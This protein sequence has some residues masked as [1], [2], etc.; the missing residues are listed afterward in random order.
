MKDTAKGCMLLELMHSSSFAQWAL[1]FGIA[2]AEVIAR[3]SSKDGISLHCRGRHCKGACRVTAP[4]TV[5][6]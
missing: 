2:T 5:S 4:R 6:R 1:T 3:T